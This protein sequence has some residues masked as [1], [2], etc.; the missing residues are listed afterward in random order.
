VALNLILDCMHDF[1]EGVVPFVIMLV[2]RN[3]SKTDRYNLS[4]KELNDRF[5]RFGYG[6]YDKKK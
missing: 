5:K 4:A 2:L 1:L 6:F 3:L